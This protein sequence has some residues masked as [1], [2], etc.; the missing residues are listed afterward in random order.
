MATHSSILAWRILWREEPDGLQSLVLQRFE[1]NLVTKQQQY[2]FSRLP[3][4][5]NMLI[6][7]H[8][9]QVGIGRQTSL[10]VCAGHFLRQLYSR[11]QTSGVSAE[12]LQCFQKH[13]TLAGIDLHCLFP[14]ALCFCLKTF[15]NIS[16][17]FHAQVSRGT[18][19][20]WFRA[21]LACLL[22]LSVQYSS[23]TQSCLT[24]SEA[25]DCHMLGF[26]VHHQLMQLAQTHVHQVGDAIQPS[27]PLSSPS[28]PAFNL[29]N[30]QG[31]FL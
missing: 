1:H 19:Q 12:S 9:I 17:S 2:H 8:F 16:H 10:S 4:Y 26:P 13:H 20:P 6:S 31:L 23:V 7:K 25:M 28:P 27:H 3:I 22:H 21:C 14:S 24:L 15:S 18:Q 5:D 29:S 30:H 11:T